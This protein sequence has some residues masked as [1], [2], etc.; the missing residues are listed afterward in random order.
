VFHGLRSIFC[1]ELTG[2]EPVSGNGYTKVS[3]NEVFLFDRMCNTIGQ[4]SIREIKE[5]QKD[6]RNRFAYL[7]PSSQRRQGGNSKNITPNTCYGTFTSI[8]GSSYYA[9]AAA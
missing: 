9:R 8:D 4:L 7:S 3:P 5:K 6:S 1:V 2:I